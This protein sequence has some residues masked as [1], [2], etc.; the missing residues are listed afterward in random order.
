[1]SIV[2]VD[3]RIEIGINPAVLK[4]A[5]EWRGKTIFEAASKV[6]KKP[7]DI[8][9]W[10]QNIG[11]PTVKQARALAQ[12]YDRPFLELFLETPP[13]IAMPELV[14]DY[15][16][17]AG[18]KAEGSNRDLKFIQQWADTK[19]SEAL[20]LYDELGI[21]PP[22]LPAYLF[23]KLDDSPERVAALSREAMSFPIQE[24]FRLTKA[25]ARI[26][27]TILREK[28]ESIGVLTLRRP[29][30]KRFAAQGICLA[31]FPLP[32]IVVQNEAPAAQSFTLVHEF[33]HILLGQSGISGERTR[34]S[35][36]TPIEAWCN[37]FAAAFLMPIEQVSALM[38]AKPSRPDISVTD[39]E[40][41]RMADIFRVSAH[42]ALIRLVQLGYVQE[43]YYW[44]I[45]KPRFDDDER[46][47]KSFGRARYYGV[48]YRS[49][50]GDLYTG[51]VLEAWMSGRITNH[52]A[53]EYLGIKNLDHLENIRADF[54][55]T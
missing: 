46:E 22:E 11:S 21:D 7:A 20:D 47:F 33:G 48:R 40:L 2:A 36:R 37:R 1:M 51:L 31:H 35:D 34:E 53:A 38:G 15:R 30:L 39:D 41:A 4:W 54:A 49:E 43:S 18:A 42:A 50:H 17:H 55:T 23:T 19:R 25:D 9:N 14:P 3:K 28:F 29:D 44:D 27:P 8:V 52:H 6:K 5:R 24:Q 16:M 26:L 13:Q 32:V 12:L 10:E 45:K